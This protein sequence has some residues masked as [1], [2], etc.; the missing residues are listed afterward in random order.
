[1]RL[2]E[3]VIL[4]PIPFSRPSDIPSPPLLGPKDLSDGQA[5]FQIRPREGPISSTCQDA[6]D[7]HPKM[8]LFGS[9]GFLPVAISNDES[10]HQMSTACRFSCSTQDSRARREP[11][12]SILADERHGPEEPYAGGG[13]NS[14]WRL[15]WRQPPNHSPRHLC[16]RLVVLSTLESDSPFRAVKILSSVPLRE[17]RRLFENQV[18]FT[19]APWWQ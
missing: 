10:T 13:P 3:L 6:F 17:K 16:H 11:P 19:N 4:S 8:T 15:S 18:P 7:S 1:M 12:D 2:K 14:R 9:R 5:C